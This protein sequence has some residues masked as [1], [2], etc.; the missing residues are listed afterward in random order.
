MAGH[1]GMGERYGNGIMSAY[2]ADGAQSSCPLLGFIV[3]C[4]SRAKKLCNWRY[5]RKKDIETDHCITIPSV[6]FF[7]GRHSKSGGALGI[8]E[9]HCRYQSRN[10]VVMMRL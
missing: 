9:L 10:T 4:Y 7:Y 3:L 1:K 6:V 5:K 8:Q 2:G